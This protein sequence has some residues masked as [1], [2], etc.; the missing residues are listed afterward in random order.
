MVV[1]WG[2]GNARYLLQL[3]DVKFSPATHSPLNFTGTLPKPVSLKLS[4]SGQNPAV[5][6]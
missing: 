2:K 4:D 3:A 6:N 5:M 1:H